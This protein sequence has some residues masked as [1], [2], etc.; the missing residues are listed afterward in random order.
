MISSILLHQNLILFQWNSIHFNSNLI[1]KKNRESV[2]E[3]HPTTSVEK[4]L[5]QLLGRTVAR[6]DIYSKG[7]LPPKKDAL[8]VNNTKIFF[9]NNKST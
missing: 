8:Q 1:V 6:M 9:T 7:H 4:G 2:C 3:N 5:G